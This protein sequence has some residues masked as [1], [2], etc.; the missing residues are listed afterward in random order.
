MASVPVTESS[1]EKFQRLASQWHKAVDHLSS[2][3]ARIGHPA[4]QEIIDL[5]PAII[6]FLLRDLEK[7]STHWFYALQKITGADPVAESAAGNVPRMAEAW[8]Q[9]GRLNGYRW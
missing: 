2:T 4:Y 6:P 9:W 5:G 1:A 7:N 8:L 3:T